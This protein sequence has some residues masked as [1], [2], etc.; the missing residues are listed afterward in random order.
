[1][2]YQ[3]NAKFFMEGE[4]LNSEK[5]TDAIG[6]HPT[7]TKRIEDYPYKEYASNSW[8]YEIEIIETLDIDDL[9][10]LLMKTL[11]PHKQRII[12]FCAQYDLKTYIKFVI[13]SPDDSWPVM[14]LSRDFIQF[15]AE[16]K[17]EVQFG[18]YC[19]LDVDLSQYAL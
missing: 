11:E 4:K 6:L 3:V 1:M 18:L 19:C 16:L 17:A 9:A 5:A 8:T 13:E 10:V 15:A 14:A 7:Q 12:D 2:N